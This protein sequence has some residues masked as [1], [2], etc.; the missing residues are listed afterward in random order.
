M[1]EHEKAIEARR[2]TAENEGYAATPMGI[3]HAIKRATTVTPEEFDRA[4]G[5]LMSRLG[6]G[7]DWQALRAAFAAAGFEVEP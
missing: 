3:G 6:Q 7:H 1:S 4:Y 5:A 2:E